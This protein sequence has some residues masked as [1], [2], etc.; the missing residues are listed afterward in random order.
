MRLF[1]KKHF[2]TAVIFFFFFSHLNA[3][4]LLVHKTA[5]FDIIYS[6]RSEKTAALIAEYAD[7]YAEEIA[8]KLHKKILVRMPVYIAPGKEALNGF[9]TFFPHPRI[10]VFDTTPEDGA[11]GNLSD[12]I[13]KVFYHE[14]THAISLIYFLP[15]L[16]L[17]FSEGVAVLYESADGMQG[18]LNDPLIYHH[19]MQGRIDGKTPSWKEAAGHRD[20]YPGAFWGYIYGSAFADY[21]QKI[22]GMDQYAKYWQNSFYIF[23]KSKTKKIFEKDLNT[24]WNNFIESI[25]FPQDAAMPIPL[26]TKNNKSGFNVTAACSKGFACFD[27]AKKSVDLYSSDG[28]KKRLFKANQSLSNLSF[29]PDGNFLLVTDIIKTVHGE[30]SRAV[31]FDME[32]RKFLKQEYCSIR[33]AAFYSADG[34]CGVEISGQFS[35][36]VLI[37]IHSFDKKE[38]VFKAGPG[39]QYTAIY[40]PVFAGKNKIAF[41]A[42]NGMERDILIL[43]TVS[44]E[45]KKLQFEKPLPAIRYLQTNNSYEKP[46]LTFS[47]AEKNM[48][49]RAASYNV[50]TGTLKIL[51]KDISGGVFFPVMISGQDTAAD[52]AVK[53]D[54]SDNQKEIFYIGLHAKYNSIYKIDESSFTQA[55]S[56]LS[57]FK[58]ADDLE[59]KSKPPKPEI[60]QPKKYNYLSWMWRVFPFLYPEIPNDL[61]DWRKTGL[62][63]FIL[64]GDPTDLLEFKTHSVFY[65]KPF[66]YQTDINVKINTEPAGFNINVYDINHDFVY[67]RIGSTFSASVNIPTKLL[68]QNITINGGLSAEAF[69]F[70]TGEKKN[71]YDYK[72]GNPVLSEQ[73]AADYTYLKTKYRLDTRFFVK[74]MMGVKINLGIKHGMHLPSKTN[75]FAV[76]ARTSLYTPVVPFNLRLSAYAGYNSYFAPQTG[77]YKFFENYAFLGFNSYIPDMQE[78]R[79]AAKKEARSLGKTNFGFGLDGELTIFSYDMQTGDSFLPIFYNRVNINAG[80]KTVFNFLNNGAKKY[81][82]NFYQSIYGKIFII[83][84]GRAIL[85]IEYAHPLEKNV[86]I[87]RFNLL[88]NVNF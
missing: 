4:K 14:L 13:L 70:F 41:I 72:L 33:S 87:G 54:K 53:T 66:F 71:L 62:T 59:I 15:V 80:Y 85:G 74:D 22:Y 81:N 38:S 3:E 30:K 9:F 60:L 61:S 84:S 37:D 36:L 75:A 21:L 44:K 35:K 82:M 78:Y 51:E 11:L 23:P 18:R 55:K 5:Y 64:G 86:K 67:R 16:P 69:S 28:K 34:F 79:Q 65:F 29:S 56:F 7:G 10:T 48:L 31:I 40:N 77:K 20:V 47:W 50:K 73:V 12:S 43:D 49:Y 63:L 6:E 83:I 52:E 42:A 27:F 2:F 46:V 58:T 88:F 8:S 26:F 76:Q 19:L 39:L 17:S 25:Y 57:D 24:L 45:I 68:S 1:S 32:R